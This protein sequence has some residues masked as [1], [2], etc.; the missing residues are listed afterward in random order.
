[1]R[2]TLLFLITLLSI[3]LS[4]QSNNHPSILIQ[5]GDELR[6]K[7][8]VEN[9]PSMAVLQ[10]VIIKESNVI[11]SLPYLKYEKIGK[12]LLDVS[13]ECLRRVFYLSYSYQITGEEKY[14][15]RAEKEMLAVCTFSDWNPTHFLDVAEMTLGVSIGY[16]WT[17]N[18][19]PQTSRNIISQ[20]IIN[21]GIKP[22]MD[23]K[24][25]YWLQGNSNWNQVCNAGIMFGA[26]AV[27]DIEPELSKIIIDR[28]L[29]S[30]A[31]PMKE[32]E[33]DGTFPEG[34]MYWGYGTTFNVM[35]ISA[36]EKLLGNNLFPISK[37]PGFIRSETN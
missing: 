37:M 14:A 27:K 6:I 19:L 24:Y 12:R 3:Q 23:S 29:K 25:N 31:I 20:A 22:S 8:F 28:S 30:I 15:N 9:S 2:K 5:P 17:Y 4:A 35:L 11:L 36:A 26:I 16:D 7:Q 10:N 21:Y 34:F 1:M 13:R 32:Y 33:P 18:Y